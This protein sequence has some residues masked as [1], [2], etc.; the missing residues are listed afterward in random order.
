MSL[1][2]TL[3]GLALLASLSGCQHFRK[4]AASCNKPTMYAGATSVA[5][6]K[7]PAGVERPDT[8]AAL[9]IPAL[10]EPM[11]PPRKSGDPCLDQ[12]PLYAV[13]KPAAKP[14]GPTPG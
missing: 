6:I 4:L 9:K 13:P 5:P 2:Y 8:H 10:N 7:V 11:P 1:R 12:P 3:I 14:A